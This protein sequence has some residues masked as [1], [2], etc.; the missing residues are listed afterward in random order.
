MAYPIAVW[1]IGPDGDVLRAC[2]LFPWRWL[3]CPRAVA[4]VETHERLLAGGEDCRSRVEA[5]ARRCLGRVQRQIK[6]F[7]GD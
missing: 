5:E 1:F 6:R 4:V 7:A 3:S 2:R